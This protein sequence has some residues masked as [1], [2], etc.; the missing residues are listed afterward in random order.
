LA[1]AVPTSLLVVG[2]SAATAVL[3]RL[4]A[5]QIQWR[6]AT[7]VGGVINSAARERSADR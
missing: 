3:P 5:R 1:A 4:R 2:I 7:I 6:L